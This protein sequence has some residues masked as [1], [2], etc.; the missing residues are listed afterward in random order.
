[1]LGSATTE[2]QDSCFHAIRRF[3]FERYIYDLV[4]L[5]FHMRVLLSIQTARPTLITHRT[6]SMH[7]RT[8]NSWLTAGRQQIYEK[9]ISG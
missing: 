3:Q 6:I 2:V 8:A 4:T 9:D 7:A 5:P 1:M